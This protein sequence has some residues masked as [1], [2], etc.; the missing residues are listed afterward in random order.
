MVSNALDAN[1]SLHASIVGTL[2]NAIPPNQRQRLADHFEA[3]PAAAVSAKAVAPVQAKL[4]AGKAEPI[5]YHDEYGRWHPHQQRGKHGHH[6]GEHHHASHSYGH[7]H[8]PDGHHTGKHRG[9]GR[10]GH[11]SSEY[12]HSEAA[13]PRHEAHLTEEEA[14][15][16]QIRSY[17]ASGL[18]PP[19][20][21]AFD[22][23]DELEQKKKPA[24]VGAPVSQQKA[25][26]APNVTHE[27]PSLERPRQQQQEQVGRN[28][29]VERDKFPA[30]VSASLNPLEPPPLEAARA[31]ARTGL[32]T[33]VEPPSTEVMEPEQKAAVTTKSSPVGLSWAP[34]APSLERNPKTPP[35]R[36]AAKVQSSSSSP[37][38]KQ[39]PPPI[40][41]VGKQQRTAAAA[42]SDTTDGFPALP[43]LDQMLAKAGLKD[44]ERVH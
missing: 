4:E 31:A 18:V 10:H 44:S 30:P 33:H 8:G 35:T 34:E 6:A 13:Y 20:F 23:D 25:K 43:S 19:M 9:Y 29:W 38:T 3:T 11:H 7:M 28:V 24:P 12:E 1:E 2:L 22:D 15:Q 36:V 16:A 42:A 37:K 40:E 39:G 32:A 21:E 5:E 27:A 17:V 14:T 41:Y 26:Y